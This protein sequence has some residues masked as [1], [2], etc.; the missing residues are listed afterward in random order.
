MYLIKLSKNNF[1]TIIKLYNRYKVEKRFC[2]IV[3]KRN[4]LA[5]HDNYI[6]IV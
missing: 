1:I 6:I 3:P 4:T 5:I 2:L